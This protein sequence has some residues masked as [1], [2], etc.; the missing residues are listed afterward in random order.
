[1]FSLAYVFIYCLKTW[2]NCVFGKA[3]KLGVE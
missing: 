2:A 1:M 3:S